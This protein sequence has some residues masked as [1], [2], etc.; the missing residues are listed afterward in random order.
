M[1]R[2]RSISCCRCAR[3]ASPSSPPMMR[4][5]ADTACAAAGTDAVVKMYGRARC[6]SHS[7]TVSCAA[8]NA[9]RDAGRLAERADRNQVRRAQR[10]LRDRAAALRAEHAEAVRVVDD[11]PGAV[12]FREFEQT[13]QRRDVAVHA[14]HGVG[15]DHLDVGVR[16]VEHR[17]QRVHIAVRIDLHVGAGQARAVDQ[18][19]VIQRVGEERR[20]AARERGEHGEVGHVAGAEVERA[21]RR[22]RSRRRIPRDRLRV[23]RARASGRRAD[24]NR[25]C[26]RRS[27]ARL[28]RSLRSVADARRG[29]DSRC[30]R[31]R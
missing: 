26:R 28:Q 18:R 8:T 19:R 21:R 11:Q 24:A 22:R 20:A 5:L 6:T 14:E 31:S 10:G 9:P 1:A 25:R 7:I 13:R 23:A 27:A 3:R 2:V 29:R 12:P 17:A 30:W 16:R 4:R 15:D